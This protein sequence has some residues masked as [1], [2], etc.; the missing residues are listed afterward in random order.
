[1]S[2]G[3]GDRQTPRASGDRS[4]AISAK[5]GP[6][7]AGGD[8]GQ[9]YAASYV[10]G[11]L[12]TYTGGASDALIGLRHSGCSNNCWLSGSIDEARVYNVPLSLCQIRTLQ[13]VP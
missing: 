13:P 4:P 3:G 2:A 5:T 10:Q 8:N 12:Q 1:M 7:K 11:A 6:S 9:P